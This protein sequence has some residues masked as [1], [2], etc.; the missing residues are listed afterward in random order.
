MMRTVICYAEFHSIFSGWK[1]YFFEPL[2]MYIL[3]GLV[4][5]RRWKYN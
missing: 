5:L 3:V 1:S 2:N 4:M